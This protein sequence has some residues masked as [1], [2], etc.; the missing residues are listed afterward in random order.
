MQ[1]EKQEKAAQLF[2]KYHYFVEKV[3]FCAAP[4]IQLQE[5]IVNDAFLDFIRKADQWDLDQDVR[6]LLKRITII[7][8]RRYWRDY[9]RSLPESLQT[10]AE[11]AKEEDR[12]D[13]SPNL[14]DQLE[15]M[16]IC[17][18]K[19]AQ[20]AQNLLDLHY[21]RQLSCKQIA[22]ETGQSRESVYT[23]L[24]RIRSILRDCMEHALR[25]S[26]SHE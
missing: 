16:E 11:I 9:V 24:S 13:H 23:A 14:E 21:F 15:S 4:S 7:S 25:W 26:T 5:D 6:P 18:K 2:L 19:L 8:A 1:T 22:E 17:M 12:S 20:K 3:A 10:L